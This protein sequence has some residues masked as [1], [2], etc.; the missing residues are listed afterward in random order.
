MKNL[1][2]TLLLIG[3]CVG[4]VEVHDAWAD[5]EKTAYVKSVSAT[6]TK[7]DCS[8]VVRYES[9]KGIGYT[10]SYVGPCE[11]VKV[12]AGDD[13]T[14][15]FYSLFCETSPCVPDSLKKTPAPTYRP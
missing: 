3:L 13:V 4:C 8:V 10:V 14:S 6:A 2:Y 12:K 11:N 9:T 15:S 5:T 1:I 7:G